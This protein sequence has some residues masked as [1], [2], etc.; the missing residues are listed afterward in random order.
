VGPALLCPQKAKEGEV[1]TPR[2]VIKLLVEILDPKPGESVYDP[3]F[4]SGGMLIISHYHV[5]EKQG[6]E[7]ARNCPFTGRRP[8]RDI[9]LCKMNLYIHDIRDVELALGDT[10]L[11]PKFKEGNALKKFNVV[12]ANPP[13]NQDGYGEEVP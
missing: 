1:Y 7:K 4:G 9:R 12:I 6:K 5:K 2:E 3:A 8:T 13:W 10:L 11:Y